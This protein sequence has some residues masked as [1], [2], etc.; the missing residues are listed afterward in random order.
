MIK[1]QEGFSPQTKDRE[2]FYIDVDQNGWKIVSRGFQDVDNRLGLNCFDCHK[3]ARPEFDLVC[4][5]DRGCNP[6]PIT[7]A[8]FGALQGADSRCQP[9][10]PVSAGDAAALKE[11][12]PAIE[13]L[14]KSATAPK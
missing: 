6:L 1:P 3:Q 10:Q 8:M 5:N 12:G 7:R 9:I 4:E 2:F 13:Q 14:T 11:L